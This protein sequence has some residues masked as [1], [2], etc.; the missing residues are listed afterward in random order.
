MAGR[1]PTPACDDDFEAQGSVHRPT[2][3]RRCA[4]IGGVRR[5]PRQIYTSVRSPDGLAGAAS[6]TA[7]RIV[8]ALVI[9]TVGIIVVVVAL[10]LL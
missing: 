4:I 2:L 5:Q 3:R 8:V 1:Q 6:S 7:R 10:G 9:L